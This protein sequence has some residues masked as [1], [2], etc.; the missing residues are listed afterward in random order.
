MDQDKAT[1][2]NAMSEKLTGLLEPVVRSEGLILVELTYQPEKNGQVLRL[3]V[4]RPEGG[5]TLDECQMLSRQISDLLDV[6]DF[7]PERYHLE[8]SSPGLTRRIKTPRE[9]EIFAGR[10]A[11]LI[12]ADD[13]GGSRKLVGVLKGLMGDEVLLEVNGKVKAIALA[14]VAKANL[15]IDF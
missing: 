14:R 9:Y 2:A 1:A 10:L 6:E 5:V 13:Q 11:R 15:E 4:D 3:F 7:I 8:V 12:V